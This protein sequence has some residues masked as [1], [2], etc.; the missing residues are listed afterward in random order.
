MRTSRQTR[1]REALPQL[2]R[3][4][5]AAVYGWL[6][7]DSAAWGSAP[8]L[9]ADGFQCATVEA[10]GAAVRHFWV[11]SILRRHSLADGAERWRA[12][13]QSQFGDHIPVVEWP[14]QSWTAE[15]V[16]QVF[17]SMR[18]AAAPGQ[19][20][21]PLAIWKSLPKE[22]LAS[23]ARLLTLVEEEGRWPA[24]LAKAYVTMIPKAAGGSRPEDQ[25]P[26]TVLDLPYRVWAKGI[27]QE[28]KTTLHEAFLGDAALGFRAQSGTTHVAQLLQDLIALQVRRGEE[29]W[30]ISFDIRKCFDMLPWWALFGALRKA[31]VREQVVR[32]FMAFYRQ[33]LRRFRYG[34]VDG[35]EW[36]AANGAAQGCPASPDLLNILLEAFH[37][38]ARAAGLGVVVGT[39]TVPSVSYADDV[40][41][42]ARSFDEAETLVAAYLHFCALLDLEVTKIQLWW[43]GQGVRRLRV[44]ALEAETQPFFRVVGIVVGLPEAAATAL[45]L[46][47]RLPKAMAT[48]R[49][50]Q[51]LDV[52]AA[53]AAQLWRST[54]LPQVLYGCEV[55]NV[56]AAQ[57]APLTTLGKSLLAVKFPLQLNV[58]RAPEVLLGPPLGASAL[59]DPAWELRVRQLRWLQQVANL[60][61]LVGVI[62]RVVACA[63]GVW[64]EPTLSLKAALLAVGWS[65]ARNE[66]C[67]R[68]AGWPML[69]PEL[70]YP[71][72]I[73]LE[74]VDDLPEPDTV[75]TDGSLAAA[76]GAAAVMPDRD[77]AL[78]LRVPAPR[79]S[80]HCE[81]VALALA[82]QFEA[83]AVLTDSLTS[84]HLLLGWP[85]FFNNTDS[86]LC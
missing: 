73:V 78:Q 16:Q 33:L 34:Q 68:S 42:V 3:E 6:R 39:T 50:L 31:G 40:T 47:K 52:P 72:R 69:Q 36:Q 41:L 63:A 48:A 54:V 85:T 75:Y 77:K 21:V 57:L 14:R 2:W 1:W 22:W 29:I 82:M 24:A 30:L 66:V 20:G 43:N 80:T 84:L 65:I 10:V 12:L 56:T 46:E 15:R 67:L 74:P 35:A 79:S 60:Q 25:R 83:T 44:G 27:V 55:R 23:L 45:H 9:D 53:V 76:G 26:I 51:S 71:G 28:W 81:L 5:P 70:G 64:D 38:W 4:R 13:L 17:S 62:H 61:S 19:L 58:W 11:D 7:G 18:E 32:G 86:S 59:L 8:I 37:R 49:R